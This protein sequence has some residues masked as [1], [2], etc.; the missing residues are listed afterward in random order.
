[1][2][3][4]VLHICPAAGGPLASKLQQALLPVVGHEVC[5]SS[6]WWGSYVRLTM[7][8][9]GGDIRSGCNVSIT[10]FIGSFSFCQTVPITDMCLCSSTG[11]LRWSAELQGWWW[12]MVRAGSHQ[13]CLLPRMQ[14]PPEAH[15]VHAHLFLHP[16]DQWREF[17]FTEPWRSSFSCSNQMNLV[18]GRT[19][20]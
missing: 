2:A 4:F 12:H 20:S 1:M 11:G 8:C 16:V 15:S 5:T 6:D 7:I 3:K 13:L 9:A 17:L 14:H 18:E 10:S 19:L